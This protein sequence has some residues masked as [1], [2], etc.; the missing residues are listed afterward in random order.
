MGDVSAS[1]EPAALASLGDQTVGT[2]VCSKKRFELDK[3][4]ILQRWQRSQG[5]L[6]R[7]TAFAKE[8]TTFFYLICFVFLVFGVNYKVHNL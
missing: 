4:N 5:R 3:N 6:K 8:F 2:G 7:A 1:E